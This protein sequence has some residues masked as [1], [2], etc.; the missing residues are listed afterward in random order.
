M[1]HQLTCDNVGGFLDWPGLR[2][3]LIRLGRQ[4]RFVAG[5]QGLKRHATNFGI[6]PLICTPFYS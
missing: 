6:T 5:V 3:L 1:D 2:R 4:F